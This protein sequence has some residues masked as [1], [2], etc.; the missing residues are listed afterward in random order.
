MAEMTSESSGEMEK[1]RAFM[2][3]QEL[4]G[5]VS[6]VVAEEVPAC[7]TRGLPMS[8]WLLAPGE[9]EMTCRLRRDS[10]AECVIRL[11]SQVSFLL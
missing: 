2:P 9:V 8:V 7:S 5:G 11:G 6:V 10:V 3:P 1:M 4:I